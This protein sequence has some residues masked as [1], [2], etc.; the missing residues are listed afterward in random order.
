MLHQSLSNWLDRHCSF[1]LGM[2]WSKI[3]LHTWIRHRDIARGIMSDI[4]DTLSTL[5]G[6]INS[7]INVGLTP[8]HLRLAKYNSPNAVS[9]AMSEIR[10][11]CR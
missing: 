6:Y 11:R 10:M 4:K 8:E 7:L 1:Q 3:K 2:R 5:C 9:T